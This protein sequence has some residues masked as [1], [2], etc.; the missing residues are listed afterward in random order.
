M[1]QGL[2]F[3]IQK[4]S[5]R[6]GPG[7]RT[8]VFLKGCPLSCWWCQNPEGI[9]AQPILDYAVSRCIGCEQC[10]D[11]CSTESLR[12]TSEGIER[13]DESCVLCGV[14]SEACPSDSRRMV[15]EVKT[16]AE[17]MARID[18]DAIFYDESGGGVTFSG[19]EPLAQPEFLTAL[20][21]AC[22]LAGIHRVVDTS[23]L[24]SR[25]VLREVAGL[26]DLFLFDVKTLDPARHREVTGVPS[27]PILANLR[28]LCEW[29][30]KVRVR[31]P[32]IP[33]INDDDRSLE[34]LGAFLGTLPRLEGVSLLPFHPS[35]KE[36]HERFGRRWRLDGAEGIPGERI[37][38]IAARMARH[39][40]ETK[41][42]G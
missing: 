26:T 36:K 20:L 23:G 4:Y 30:A 17:V 11:S 6:D 25:E 12:L 7:I 3:D 5:T 21:R 14:C 42:G 2:V 16:V 40:L 34:E 19:G 27:E 13:S 38:E 1:E 37:E 39:G 18:K 10:V 22:G 28:R 8:T 24:A 31:I 33:G 32:V 41:V 35:A 29:G 15:G 9:E